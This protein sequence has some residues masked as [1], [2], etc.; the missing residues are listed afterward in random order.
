[1]RVDKRLLRL[2]QANRF[3]LYMI[4]LLGLAGG[5]L[6]V[7]HA[8][9]LSHAITR[10]FLRG[11]SLVDLSS[12]L[13]I[14][15]TLILLRAVFVWVTETS[16]SHL[17]IRVKTD[18]RQ[19]LFD[20]IQKLGPHFQGEAKHDQKQ[21][22]GE[23]VN[24]AIEGVEAIDAYISQ[25]LPQL[26]LAALVPLALL[27]FIF[28]LDPLSG[29]VLLLTAPLIPIFMIL[30]GGVANSL[31]KRQ[32]KT[33]SRL[34]AHFLDVIQGLTTLKA[35]GR[36][37]EQIEVIAKISDHYRH[38]TLGV[39]RVA[40]LSSLVLELVA[41]LSTAVVAV[42]IGLRLLYGHID[43]EAAFFVLLLAPE[44]YLPLRMLG[45]RFHAGM[46]GATAAKRIFEILETPLPIQPVRKPAYHA[47]PSSPISISF[48]NV[49]F[50]YPNGHTALDGLSFE[51]PAGK[52]VALVGPSGAGKSTISQL[53][54]RFLH[55][56]C[57]CIRLNDLDLVEM[58]VEVSRNL[59]SWVPQ[60]PYIFHDTIATNIRM[61]RPDALWD[62]VVAAAKLAHAHEFIEQLPLGYETSVGER[63]QRLSGGQVQ[64]IALA[65]A[66]LKDAPILILDEATANLDPN[67]AALIEEA[68]NRLMED[69]TCL[70][71]AHRLNT[72][73][74]TDLVLVIDGGRLEEFGTHRQLCQR[75]GLYQRLLEAGAAKK[76]D[77]NTRLS[78][79]H[80]VQ[81]QT[82]NL[83][84]SFLGLEN[85]PVSPL[86]TPLIPISLRHLGRLLY[87][88]VP[89]LGFVALSI[90]FGFITIASGIGLM[91]TG[92]YVISAAAL[93]PSI[94]VLQVPIVGV[95]AFGISRGLF[96]YLERYVSHDVAFR[97]LA[98]MRVWFYQALE[99]LAPA[100]LIHFRSGDLLSRI[101]ADIST[102]ENFYLRAV[103]PPMVAFLVTLLIVWL[104]HL[105]HPSLAIATL[106]IILVAGVILPLIVLV[107]IRNHGWHLLNARAILNTSFLDGI[108]GMA[109]LQT[110]SGE[111]RQ[112]ERITEANQSL[113]NAQKRL[114]WVGG[115]QT[116]V[117]N[118]LAQLAALL[119]LFISIPLVHQGSIPG[120][121]LPVLVLAV[122]TSFEA[123]FPLPLAAQYLDSSL[124]ATRRL[125][126][127]IDA[128]PPVRDPIYPPHLTTPH[129]I[130][131]SRPPNK[132]PSLPSS[133]N[134]LPPE[135]EVKNLSFSYAPDECAALK[136][137]S[138]TLHRGER[139]A[140]VGPSGAGKTTLVNILL[141]FWDYQQGQIY[142]NNIDLRNYHQDHIRQVI[143]VVS[144]H[145]HLFNTTVRENLLL[146]QPLATENELIQAAV[147]A[148][149][150]DVIQALPQGYDTWIGE[151][152]SRL[153]GGER[154]RLAIAR[155]FLK[156]A[157]LLL[158]DEFTANLDTIT[159][160]KVFQVAR[161][162]MAGRST[163]LISHRLTG[164][165]DMDEI[166]VFNNGCL[167]EKGKHADLLCIR[168]LYWSMWKA[169]QNVVHSSEATGLQEQ[170]HP[171][172]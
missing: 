77:T 7:L 163:L 4:I 78:Y 42:Q 85:S 107:L 52:T 32:W 84:S 166:L 70:I 72:I 138:F 54:L 64:R 127:V 161:T 27:A 137:I 147:L 114:A 12:L 15:A 11:N 34:S 146:A 83:Q 108:Q 10:V 172:G 140:I 168:G 22:T 95:R 145:I 94:A 26:A 126:E 121:Y 58:P 37:Q 65:R 62:E 150:H 110:F 48:Q 43:F 102:L 133:L 53:L 50:T 57:G 5:V 51:I 112:S 149:I 120:V 99:P 131:N 30:I 61:A 86:P 66:F 123:I 24:T 154:Q 151:E 20:H 143:A 76:Q 117:G 103:S 49:H 171:P 119:I 81:P 101:I 1:M 156:N 67:H 88:M 35:F 124:Q 104:M 38:T 136:N 93:Q 23:L 148:Q 96:R 40:F 18:L 134:I 73:A 68:T 128:P 122:L 69:R 74:R 75:G 152:G 9:A 169:E 60:T 129:I 142:F 155:A 165:E 158:L 33:L 80:G 97:I 31:T 111:G 79:H 45:T 17:A 113:G 167:V 19:S 159:A 116:A 46:A 91:A 2:V 41:T 90:L 82:V 28:P 39:L 105:F 8:R 157:P 92:A 160:N 29:L 13:Y 87:F 36:S 125:L 162:L 100:R 6:T 16:A 132:D 3:S 170:A 139:K 44:F 153:S 21:H 71:I 55:L 141:R 118:F 25:Y 135:I 109:V 144:Q 59:I 130:T 56:D 63:G 164:L 98:R 47:P 89:S 106:V 115:M 14:L